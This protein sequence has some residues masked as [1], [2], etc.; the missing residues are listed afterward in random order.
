MSKSALYD[1]PVAAIA[2]AAPRD[3]VLLLK[4]RVAALVAFT[5]LVGMLLAGPMPHPVLAA[6]AILCIAVGAGAAG[7]INMWYEADLDARMER[8]RDRPLPAGRMEPGTALG[9]GAVLAVAS[10]AVLGLA[11]NWLA[12]ALLALAILFYVFVYTMWLKRRTPHNIVV[13]GAAGAIPPIIGWAAATGDLHPLPILL[14]AIIFMW[15]PPHFWAL[16]LYRSDDYR[17]A[18]VPMLP[19]IAG[20]ESTRRHIL[21][22]A[23]VL[24]PLSLAPVAAGYAHAVYGLGAAVLG[25]AFVALAAILWRRRGEAP[26]RRLFAFSIAYLFLIFLLLTIDNAWRVGLA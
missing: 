9:F 17:R 13:G 6:T 23:L 19:V 26:A 12:A 16:S 8:T 1:A 25:T 15:T 3:F 20:A 10:V 4:P 24:A 14:F 11:T 18:R 22:Y 5:G 7:A 2:G 21:G